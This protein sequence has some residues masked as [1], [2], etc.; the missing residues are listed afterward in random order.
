M[1]NYGGGVS[2]VL[3]PDGTEYTE[4]I[5]QQGKPPCDAEFNLLQEL[6][7]NYTRRAVLRGTPSG[8]LGNDTNTSTVFRTNRMWSNWFQFG[9][10]RPG[11]QKAVLWAVVNGWVIPVTGTR[12]G[13]PPGSPNDTDTWNKIALDPPPS[14]AGDFRIDFVFLEVWQARIPPNPSTL[15]K[16]NLASVY[17]YG[18][19]EGG[20]S[21][22][23]DDLIDPALGFETS[24]RVQ[25]QYRIRVVKGLVGFTN[26]PDGFDPATV[27][28]KGAYDPANPDTAT[29][30]TFTNMRQA[31]GDPGLW[32]AG[33]GT[34]NTLG[35]VDGYVYAIP[36]AAL[37]R[38]NSILWTGDP[39]QNLNGGFNR[40][41]SAVSRAG[42][43]T[44]T[45]VPVLSAD[46]AAGALSLN[47]NT[48]SGIPM[49]LTPLT[50]V[51]VR[52]GDEVLSYQS[53]TGGGAMAIVARG[54][55]GSRDEAH[56]AGTPVEI[57]SD[58]PD[59]LFSDQVALT[60]ILDLRHVVSPNGFDY[61]ALLEENV[62]RLLRG[63]LRSNWKRSGAGPQGPVIFY[64]DKI[65][66]D[67]PSL[68]ITR[69]D[70]PDNIRTTFSDAAVLQRI[71]LVALP[72]GVA[73]PVNVNDPNWSLSLTIT[74]TTKGG[75]GVFFQPGDVLT[76][77]VAQL[78]TGVPPGDADQI[79]WLND[80]ALDVSIRVD[81]QAAPV[82]P[83]A[84]TVTPIN[85]G[86]NDD[87]V[88]TLGVNFPTTPNRLYIT[89]HVLYGPGRGISRR[90]DMLHSVVVSSPSSDLLLKQ[91]EVSANSFEL[92][93]RPLGTW[94]KY[95]AVAGKPT[96]PSTSEVYAELGS[97]TLVVQPFR[98]LDMPDFSITM[99]GQIA[100]KGV[101]L[102][103]NG[104]IAT[105]VGNV[106]TDGANFTAIPAGAVVEF[107][108]GPNAGRRY[109][110][111]TASSPNLG[112]TL[113][114][115]SSY[116]LVN[117]PNVN[118]Q[119]HQSAGL[120]PLTDPAGAAKW[121]T[122]DPLNV[123]SGA[124]DP[125]TATKNIYVTFP[126]GL[127]PGWGEYAVPIL[128]D[129]Q[130]PFSRGLNYMLNVP[131][132]AGPFPDSQKNYVPF[133]FGGGD[134]YAT[135]STAIV[136]A[137]YNLPLTY[138]AAGGGNFGRTYAGIRKFTDTRGLG[139][140]GLEFPPFYGL[141][142]VWAV[143]EAADYGVNNSAFDSLTRAPNN[144][145]GRAK[146]LLRQDVQGPLFWVEIDEDGDSTFILNAEAIDI[147]KS[148]NPIASFAAG[149]FVVEA[150]IYG[151]DRGSFDLTKEFRLVLSRG[152]SQ[153]V[154][155]AR[156]ANL[157]V[158]I[159]SPEM[160]LPG[161]LQG[162]DDLLINYTRTAYQGDAWGVQTVYTDIGFLQGPLTSAVAVA[163]G[164]PLDEN[165]LT[166]P[167]QKA[168]EILAATSFTT[169]LGT[170]RLVVDSFE[171]QPSPTTVGYEDKATGWPPTSPIAPRPLIKLGA[172]FGTPDSPLSTTY[173]GCVERLPLGALWRDKDFRGNQFIPGGPSGLLHH[174]DTF[175]AFAS[176]FAIANATEQRDV[177]P[178]TA[179]LAGKV[180]DFLVH[181]DGTQGNYGPPFVN[182]RVNRGGSAFSATFPTPGGAVLASHA[183]ALQ[184]PFAAPATAV[185]ALTC[186]AF[187]VRNAV[188]NVGLN[189]V[190]A[191]SELMLYIQTTASFP[192]A[193]PSEWFTGISSNGI[194]E[195]HSAADLFHI[196]GRPLTTDYRR[197]VIDPATIPL[198]RRLPEP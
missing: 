172:L 190:S 137:P 54:L 126:R 65:T 62:D 50:P 1:N 106:L 90:P 115:P 104:G 92:K 181:V 134:T 164:N 45:T 25:V 148:P 96:I 153:A 8:W 109:A 118:Y 40:N 84:Y 146:N 100:N 127:I 97:K 19:V 72:T 125:T 185:S 88:I 93:V 169:S 22:L 80:F 42:V 159:N 103:T 61:Q 196:E 116:P 149:N 71:E 160:I 5:L 123:F 167:N 68:G 27:K 102:A 73:P 69:L 195:G 131:S 99:D 171:I 186:R 55:F 174:T 59:G 89:A 76:V 168:L 117:D 188:T 114:N 107:F 64:E 141:A 3:S 36:I 14:N 124:L 129:D 155:V 32:R 180:G 33:D 83:G 56:K 183:V 198:T 26:Y 161:P 152:R 189:E 78:K 58:R 43:Q 176:G 16:P 66:N 17:R 158:A 79:R 147:T 119:I 166:R 142:R 163:L 112:L 173:H 21:F 9:L 162:S 37:F 2:R 11:E 151:F 175:G 91:Q 77:P 101:F 128:W 113:Q 140:Q 170:G 57:L 86:P 122:T 194:L 30:F 85:P 121:A 18:N 35:T 133:N 135:F 46:L 4:V 13:A 47:M 38:R 10:Q 197:I 136:T 82:D 177:L 67:P 20:Y 105:I 192:E 81:G 182:Y 87:L 31:M 156:S 145:V 48:G 34:A 44:F 75:P 120:M 144:I 138:N 154:N 165:N 53:I 110:V 39:A 23:P 132:G 157:Q 24:Q 179:E 178:G 187:L 150:T 63:Q 49:P 94:A 15:N 108:S 143:Y 6:G 28:A 139:R 111:T 191:G 193:M 12:T 41:P 130:A 29:S 60:D 184:A 74:Q 98:R 7:V 52:V 70:G 51:Y 95:R